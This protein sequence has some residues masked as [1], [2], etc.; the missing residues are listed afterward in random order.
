M[1]P[2]TLRGS[3]TALAT[4]MTPEGIDEAALE[5]LIEWQIAQGTHGLV[6]CGTT[7]ESPT[8]SHEEHRRVIEMTVR[9]AAGRVHVM[10]GA[11]SNSTQET[12]ELSR[13]AKDAGADSVLL[14]APYYNKPNAAGQ[15]AHFSA[16]AEAVDL[17]IVL[18][19]IPGRSVIDISDDTI[20]TLAER[21]WNIIGVKDATG[22]LARVATLHR[23][24][25]DRLALLSGEDMTA[26]AFNIMGG[27]GCI[28]VS[29]NVA[30]ALCAQLQDACIAGE[31]ERAQNL[32]YSLVALHEAMFL[33]TSPAPVKYALHR[34][35]KMAPTIRLPLVPVSSATAQRVDAAL[36]EL[37]LI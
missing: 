20:L 12:L 35:G 5:S 19:N 11:G 21:H 7:G 1:T 37:D 26:L 6:P 16:V 24:A 9:I 32:H 29:A 23:R 8:L 2:E 3:F 18:Y 30:P 13:F 28:S 36:S 17:P 14:V 10:A 27:Q 22:D 31:Y 33:E 25:G 34:M 4:P 15:I